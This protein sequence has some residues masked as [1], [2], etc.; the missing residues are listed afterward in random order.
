MSHHLPSNNDNL[1][2]AFDGSPMDLLPDTTTTTTLTTS[3][4]NGLFVDPPLPPVVGTNKHTEFNF[5]H[6]FPHMFNSN[7]ATTLASVEKNNNVSTDTTSGRQLDANIALLEMGVDGVNYA[8]QTLGNQASPSIH[9]IQ[10]QQHNLTA[11]ALC[12]NT[13]NGLMGRYCTPCVHDTKE[14]KDARCDLLTSCAMLANQSRVVNIMDE[15]QNVAMSSHKT[16]IVVYDNIPQGTVLA[17]PTRTQTRINM[18]KFPTVGNQNKLTTDWN[19]N[20]LLA[21]ITSTCMS[22]PNGKMITIFRAQNKTYGSVFP[23]I[24]RVYGQ[25][26]Q[27]NPP[28]Q[29]FHIH[30]AETPDGKRNPNNSTVVTEVNPNDSNIP[31]DNR[32]GVLLSQ[33][34][35]EEY[36]VAFHIKPNASNA[37]ANTGRSCPVI[38]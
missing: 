13:M 34:Y 21:N 1:W 27:D 32:A 6:D 16:G 7:T 30:I 17:N 14:F 23:I 31:I 38:I 10:T 5:E 12:I 28:Q 22:L 20:D 3:I 25:R 11:V 33:N 18:C 35:V 19:L 24:I 8:I 29:E 36:T 9:N 2:D 15:V 4:A 37:K 26:R